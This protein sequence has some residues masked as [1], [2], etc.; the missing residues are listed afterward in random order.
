MAS[1]CT[2]CGNPMDETSGICK[3]QSCPS[4]EKMSQIHTVPVTTVDTPPQGNNT[5]NSEDLKSAGSALL[6]GLRKFFFAPKEKGG[7][8]KISAVIQVFTVLLTLFY[9]LPLFSVSCE[10]MSAAKFTGLNATFG[11]TIGNSSIWGSDLNQRIDG[12]V[13][14]IFILL[15]PVA[16]FFLLQFKDKVQLIRDKAMSI[17]TILSGLGIVVFIVLAIT[18][19]NKAAQNA[20]RANF[21]GAY[22]WSII[23]YVISG[24]LSGFGWWQQTKRKR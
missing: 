5:F 23:F 3:N 15:I 6:M 12:N 7:G 9:F 14:A 20:V 16:I 13:A 10:G 21:T 18:V 22:T 2:M 17:S 1:F 24:L 11:K 19:N 4:R 8:L